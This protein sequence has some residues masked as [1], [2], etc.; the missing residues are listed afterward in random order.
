MVFNDTTN[1]SGLIQSFE[2]WAG[3][4]DGD[5]SGDTNFLKRVTA[6]INRRLSYYMN[7]MGATSRR[8]RVDDLNY[9]KQF[10]AYFDI[11][12]GQHDYEFLTDADGNTITDITAVLLSQNSKFTELDRVP[13]NDDDALLIMSPNSD[14]TGI[15]YRYVEKNNTIFLNPV[16][17][18]DLSQGGKIFFKRV[19]SYFVYTD[20]TKEPG[21]VEDYHEML[22]LGAAFDWCAVNKPNN[23]V[24][25]STLER[26]LDKYERQWKAYINL[27]NPE[28]RNLSPKMENLR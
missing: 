20:T 12:S 28:H 18:Y 17:N 26:K 8:S 21:I 19:P 27:R 22:S 6:L 13:G 15:P 4:N 25:L 16:P 24:L 10:F 1:K 11:K 3:L 9:D 14:D 23:Q 2:F 5:V 7:M